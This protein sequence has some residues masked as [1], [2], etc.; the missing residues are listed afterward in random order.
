MTKHREGQG[1]RRSGKRDLHYFTDVKMKHK[2]KVCLMNMCHVQYVGNCRLVSVVCL[3]GP[4]RT[5]ICRRLFPPFP[6]CLAQLLLLSSFS[7]SSF[8]SSISSFPFRRVEREKRD[9]SDGN[10]ATTR[11]N[12]KKYHDLH[13]IFFVYIYLASTLACHVI[14]STYMC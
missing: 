7:P 8:S 14:E 13:H 5:R 4:A 11:Q 10:K 6:I 2:Q 3:P 12:R 9:R 1:K